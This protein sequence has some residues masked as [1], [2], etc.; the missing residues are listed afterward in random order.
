MKSYRKNYIHRN[1][2]I[3]IAFLILSFAVSVMAQDIPKEEDYFKSAPVL[4]PHTVI[5]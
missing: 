2:L 5:L 3:L 1:N 4:A